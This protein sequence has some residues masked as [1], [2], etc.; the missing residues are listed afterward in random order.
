MLKETFERTIRQLCEDI[1]SEPR[2][3]ALP[4]KDHR[5]LAENV[6]GPVVDALAHRTEGN[7]RRK[8]AP[9]R[10]RRRGG[11]EAAGGRE[12]RARGLQIRGR[13]HGRDRP[14]K[15][16]VNIKEF[17]DFEK[18]RIRHA[19]KYDKVMYPEARAEDK[20]RC[21]LGVPLLLKSIGESEAS[22]N[23]GWRVIGVLK[24][25]NVIESQTPG[26]LLHPA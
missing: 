13:S 2:P 23:Q 11:Q 10:R 17:H 18:Y 5:P 9:S 8:T 26:V 14:A 19:R 6:C 16:T 15:E 7:R 3:K 22:E 25:E 1:L 20:C 4:G 24:L 12:R 21:V